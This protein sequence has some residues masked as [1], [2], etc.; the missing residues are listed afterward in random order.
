[1]DT[2]PTAAFG[3]AEIRVVVGKTGW[4]IAVDADRHPASVLARAGDGA[5]TF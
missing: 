1:M 3:T 4:I 5:A 2:R